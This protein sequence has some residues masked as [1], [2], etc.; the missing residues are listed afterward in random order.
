MKQEMKGSFAGPA[1]M[2][3]DVQKVE[4]GKFPRRSPREEF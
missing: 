1:A 3:P 2:E 4:S